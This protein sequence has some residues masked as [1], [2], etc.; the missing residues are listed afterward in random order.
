MSTMMFGRIK[1]VT[2]FACLTFA[3]LSTAS[4]DLTLLFTRSWGQYGAG[5]SAED[6]EPRVSDS[7]LDSFDVN[8]AANV[9]RGPT[10]LEAS[11]GTAR[12]RCSFNYR[13]VWT[14]TE[15]R[16]SDSIAVDGQAGFFQ[17]DQIHLYPADAGGGAE[18][19]FTFN[20]EPTED[21]CWTLTFTI[22]GT[23]GIRVYADDGDDSILG[24]GT[25]PNETYVSGTLTYLFRAG[26][27]YGF[28]IAATAGCNTVSPSLTSCSDASAWSFVFTR[29]GNCCPADFNGDQGVDGDDVIAFFAAWDA[30]DPA[31]DFNGD[32]GVDG[33]DVIA[34]FTRWDAGC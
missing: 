24:V 32:Q 11:V 8:V 17:Q 6:S 23:G 21:E 13:T 27:Q 14:P 16:G 1:P 20:F 12:G 31:A 4:A 26:Q 5:A 34:F 30:A 15:I 29:G 7:D 2:A 28:R 18:S 19:G 9:S 22:A 3:M 25:A 33:D 10:L